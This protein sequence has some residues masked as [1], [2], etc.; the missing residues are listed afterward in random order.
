VRVV[1]LAGIHIGH[2]TA[3][4]PSRQVWPP[5]HRAETNSEETV[6]GMESFQDD[7]QEGMTKGI[8]FAA[9]PGREF[10]PMTQV[11]SRELFAIHDKPMIYYP[12][13]ALMMAGIRDLLIVSSPRDVRN[14]MELLGN[15]SRL[16]I[17]ISYAERPANNGIAHSLLEAE[18]FIEE[19][20]VCVILSHTIL[21]GELF[22]LRDAVECPRGATLFAYP[23]RRSQRTFLTG[24]GPDPGQF[25]RR[26]HKPMDAPAAEERSLCGTAMACR[27]EAGVAGQATASPHAD[28]RPVVE[29]GLTGEAVCLRAGDS[30]SP[31]DYTAIGVYLFDEKVVK[32]ARSLESQA[33]F[34]QHAHRGTAS[35][36]S[37]GAVPQLSQTSSPPPARFDIVDLCEEYL[38][39]R[40]LRV[41]PLPPDTVWVRTETEADLLRAGNFIASLEKRQGLKVGCIEEAAFRMGFIDATRLER[42]TSDLP[43]N[44]YREYLMK[45]AR[46]AHATV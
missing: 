24:E 29:F 33:C 38:L 4:F 7:R 22:S 12:L 21:H 17:S 41:Q 19:A 18:H 14:L 32:V 16:G 23:S 26:R 6:H 10:H 37:H 42:L 45:L 28:R 15:G 40:S 31:C 36:E 2:A 35:T 25:P 30:A 11:V 44:G 46:T 20:P 39:R 1:M 34:Q 43:P 13:W 8:I 27:M 5:L 3:E 9:D